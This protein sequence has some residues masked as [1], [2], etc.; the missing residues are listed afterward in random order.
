MLTVVRKKVSNHKISGMPIFTRYRYSAF[1]ERQNCMSRR[2]RHFGDNA[3]NPSHHSITKKSNLPVNQANRYAK[4]PKKC[5]VFQIVTKY[6][7]TCQ[8]TTK[9][10]ILT[11]STASSKF[12]HTLYPAI[13]RIL[14]KRVSIILI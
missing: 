4:S 1:F 6:L 14:I 12:R 11:I 3:S 8:S 2:F 13:T 7:P 9:Y 5:V 10:L